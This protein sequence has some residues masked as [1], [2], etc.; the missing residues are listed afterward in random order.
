MRRLKLIAIWIVQ[1]LMAVV[2]VG[3][4]I[5]KFTSPAWERM[6]RVWGYPDG[7]YLVIGVVEAVAG[8]GVLIPKTATP[9]AALLAVVMLGAAITQ[10]RNGRTG[11]GELVF[12]TLLGVIAIARRSD[13]FAWRRGQARRGAA[14]MPN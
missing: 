4:G 5:A 10:L 1:A 11:V 8:L 14:P 6:F 12:M 3:S 13:M 2:M 9:S 7:F